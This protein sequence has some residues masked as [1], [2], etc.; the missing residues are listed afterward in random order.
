[1]IAPADI[2][3]LRLCAA[4]ATVENIL[5]Q[6]QR[7]VN[8]E[9]LQRVLFTHHAELIGAAEALPAVIAALKPFA[10]AALLVPA[11][12]NAVLVS[13]ACPADQ[14]RTFVQFRGSDFHAAAQA[15]RQHA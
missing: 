12:Q 7:R 11:H 1:M 2:E 13:V 10:R 14:G 5:D 15:W 6:A 4:A 8:A 9:A 3:E